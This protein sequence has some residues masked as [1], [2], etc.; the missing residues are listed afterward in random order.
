MKYHQ[1]FCYVKLTCSSWENTI[2]KVYLENPEIT[3]VPYM[4]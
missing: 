1:D 4:H 2:T 3:L